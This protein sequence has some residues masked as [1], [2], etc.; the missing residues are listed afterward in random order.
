[1]LARSLC[2]LALTAAGTALSTVPASAAVYAY[3][4]LSGRHRF[5]TVQTGGSNAVLRVTQ[6]ARRRYA[7][8]WL[9]W[10]CFEL[11]K[12][13]ALLSM[14]A[15][16]GGDVRMSD[17]APIRAMRSADYCQLQVAVRTTRHTGRSGRRTTTTRT[18]KLRQTVAVTPVGQVHI[19]RI[20]GTQDLLFGSMVAFVAY[21]DNGKRFPTADKIV[22]RFPIP[23]LGA[24]D[25]VDG[26]AAA[27]RVGL[28]TDG[29]ARLRVTYGL[30]DGTQLFADQDVTTKVL[31]TNAHE[32]MDEVRRDDGWW[33]D[34]ESVSER[35]KG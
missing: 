25:R 28:W 32:E 2:L 23:S 30:P 9:E 20:R 8:R 14:E 13:D 12:E 3:P 31:T 33:G 24:L 29:A 17:V 16:S 7:G 35:T 5:V 21:F 26:T 4:S 15:E 1:M 34:A 18:R 19:D 22:A 11:S 27:G 10:R 6:D